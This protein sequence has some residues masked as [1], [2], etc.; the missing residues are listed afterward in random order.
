MGGKATAVVFGNNRQLVDGLK[1][2]VKLCLPM[3][4]PLHQTKFHAAI[5]QGEAT[6]LSSGIMVAV[7]HEDMDVSWNERWRNTSMSKYK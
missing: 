3:W 4:T 5:E 7:L 1:C 2:P 6:S